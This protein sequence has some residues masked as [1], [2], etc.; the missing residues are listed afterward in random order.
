MKLAILD[1]VN[2]VPGLKILFP[3]SE[4]YS[5][6]PDKYFFYKSTK[7]YTSFQ[8]F[9]EYGFNYRTDWD[10]INSIN[11]DYLFICSTTFDLTKDYY[12]EI[13]LKIKNIINNNN[14][15]LVVL[16][17]IFDYD[18]DPNTVLDGILKID[19]YFKR[20]YNKNKIYNKNVFPFPYIMFLKPCILSSIIYYDSSL[21]SDYLYNRA[22]W[23]GGL[24][25]HVDDELKIYRNR[26]DIY[27]Q[28]YKFID[29]NFWNNRKL[30]IENMKKYKIIIDLIGTGEPNQRTIEILTN[31]KLLMTMCVELNWGFEN[32]DDFHPDIYFSNS[33]E[34]KEKLFKLL[35]DESHYK[36]CLEQQLYITRKYFNKEWFRKY[37]INKIN[38]S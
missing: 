2:H 33:L 18:Y 25:N 19:Y 12:K 16:F 22:L 35:N 15:K 3:E 37:I 29:S 8:N 31:N 23:A 26:K 14:F 13:L 32:G 10:T 27:N 28:I 11:Y 1:P 6:E 38:I 17:D 36:I 30:Y 24:Y 21:K 20:N 4:Y 34:F 9:I 7:H 5:Y